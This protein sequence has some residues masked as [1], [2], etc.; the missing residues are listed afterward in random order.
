MIKDF[1][2]RIFVQTAKCKKCGR[3]LYSKKARELGFGPT[4]AQGGAATIERQRLEKNGQ[5]SL[6]DTEYDSQYAAEYERKFGIKVK[7]SA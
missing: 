4:C 2:N 3:P 5:L 1:F 7:K 6:I